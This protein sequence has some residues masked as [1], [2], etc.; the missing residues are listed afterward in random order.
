LLEHDGE[1]S[2]ERIDKL[3]M[4][5]AVCQIVSYISLIGVGLMWY[6]ISIYVGV[7]FILSTVLAFILIRSVMSPVTVDDA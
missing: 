1:L 7:T 2:P 6:N 4:A 5:S 3:R